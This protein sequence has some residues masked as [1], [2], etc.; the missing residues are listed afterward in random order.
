M[1]IHILYPF[2]DGPWGGANQFLKAVKEYFINKESYIENIEEANIVL[3]NSSPS[4]EFSGFVDIIKKLKIKYPNKIFIN[5]IDGPVF[6]I[7]DRNLFIDKAFYKF[8]NTICDG[9][10]FQSY[11]S[12]EK[13]IYLGMKKNHFETTILNAPNSEIF[14]KN[15]KKFFDKNEKVKIIATSWS[16]NI[17]K[18]FE[19]Y[20]WMDENLDFTKYEM[21]FIGNSPFKF[22]NIILKEPMDSETLT[23]E[24][25]RHD[26]FITASQSDPCSNSLIEAMH[27]GLPA[28]GLDDGGHTEIISRGG[29][30]FKAHG[31]IPQKLDLI[32]N[33][34]EE[35][36][37]NINLPTIDEVGE[38]Y[39]QFLKKIYHEKKASYNPKNPSFIDYLKIKSFVVLWNFEEKLYA[40][41]RRIFK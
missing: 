3:F 15:G 32:A 34:Y 29:E 28:L 2:K 33:N 9:T 13:N 40:I 27:S 24:L 19:V 20:K 17:K 1:K 26:I 38:L 23:S 35:Y 31:E 21:T 11:W 4:K 25:K 41:K 10:V 8:N 39:F 7:R 16:S 37:N 22:K 18:G 6:Y 30:V 14:N 36:Q 5:R 12:R